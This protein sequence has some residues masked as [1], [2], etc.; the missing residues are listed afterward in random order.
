MNLE[1]LVAAFRIDAKDRIA[2][3]LFAEEDVVAWLNDAQKEAAVRGRLLYESD[4]AAVCQIAVQAARAVYPLH[5][6]LYEL[7]YL[8]FESPNEACVQELSL[9]STGELDRIMPGWRSSTGSPV[10]VVQDDTTLRLVPKPSAPGLLRL[11]GYRLPLDELTADGDE[12]EIHMAHHRHLVDWAL[13]RAFSVPDADTFDP[14]RAANAERAFTVY[15]GLSPDSDLRR[16]TRHDQEHHT[17]P[18]FP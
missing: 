18:F 11:E 5:E 12:P 2:P 14:Q 15:F 3:H 7:D 9:K 6:A 16:I 17:L 8:G 10:Y 13:H 1:A 4:N